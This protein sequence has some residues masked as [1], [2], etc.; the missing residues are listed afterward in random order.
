MNEMYKYLQEHSYISEN[1][2]SNYQSELSEQRAECIANKYNS[3]VQDLEQKIK[4]QQKEFI[5]YLE[6]EIDI[7]DGFLDTVKSDL[8]EIPYGVIS[9]N[10]TYITTQIKENETAHKV[11]KE[12]LSKFKEIKGELK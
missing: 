1:K 9:A 6:N 3:L 5:S 10:K 12:I 2:K 11:Y 7:C 4:N 8:Q